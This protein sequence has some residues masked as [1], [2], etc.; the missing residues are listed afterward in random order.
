MLPMHAE[1]SGEQVPQFCP[2]TVLTL[3]THTVSHA[4]SQQN[5][6]DAQIDLAQGPQSG[7]SGAPTSQ[8]SCEHGSTQAPSQHL[9]EQHW[10]LLAQAEPVPVHGVGPQMLLEHELLQHSDGWLQK[11][12]S[13]EHIPPLQTPW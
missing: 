12:P 2:Q 10:A 4:L 3:F 1:P 9:L 8:T 13:G 11:V 5:V 6:S 7:V